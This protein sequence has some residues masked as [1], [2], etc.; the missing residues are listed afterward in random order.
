MDE[1]HHVT[2]R[3]GPYHDIG[4]KRYADKSKGKESNGV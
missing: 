3:T 2:H 4:K 1:K